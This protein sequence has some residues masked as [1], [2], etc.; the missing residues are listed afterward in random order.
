MFQSSTPKLDSHL[1]VGCLH[2]VACTRSGSGET[3]T[4]E[5]DLDS[6]RFLPYPFHPNIRAPDLRQSLHYSTERVGAAVALRSR[7]RKPS[8]P[9]LFMRRPFL[10]NGSV[11]KPLYQM[12]WFAAVITPFLVTIETNRRAFVMAVNQ[13]LKK[14]TK[15]SGLGPS[16]K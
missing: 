5:P 12:L 6:H 8:A 16:A 3:E 7:I 2:P 10:V 9:C 13:D 4:P 15:K 14:A 11:H 1:K